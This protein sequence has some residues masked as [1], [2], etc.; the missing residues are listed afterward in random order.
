[1]DVIISNAKNVRVL[2]CLF[3]KRISDEFPAAGC[4]F[5]LYVDIVSS[6]RSYCLI[7]CQLLGMPRSMGAYTRLRQLAALSRL[8]VL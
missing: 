3:P 2:Q 7:G 8:Q 5:E 1:M 4:G 6:S